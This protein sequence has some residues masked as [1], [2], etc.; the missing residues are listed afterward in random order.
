ML[1]TLRLWRKKIN[2]LKLAL[3]SW[4]IAKWNKL[5]FIVRENKEKS[6]GT[7]DFTTA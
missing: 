1:H 6:H 4:D 7:T 3:I 2:F 5:Q